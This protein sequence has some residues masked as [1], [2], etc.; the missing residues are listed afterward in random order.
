LKSEGVEMVER[1]L[2][3]RKMNCGVVVDHIPA[4]KLG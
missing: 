4:G 1:E 3:V 2:L